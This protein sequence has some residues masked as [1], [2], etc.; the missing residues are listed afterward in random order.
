LYCFEYRLHLRTVRIFDKRGGLCVWTLCVCVLCTGRAPPNRIKFLAFTTQTNTLIM[1]PPNSASFVLTYHHLFGF[2]TTTGTKF[3][4][5]RRYC[6]NCL[7]EI[8]WCR[9]FLPSSIK[10][11][12][13]NSGLSCF[14]HL[15]D[16][17]YSVKTWNQLTFGFCLSY[18]CFCP[19]L[20]WVQFPGSH[21]I[22]MESLEDP[23]KINLRR[24]NPKLYTHFSFPNHY[25]LLDD[26]LH[27]VAKDSFYIQHKKFSSLEGSLFEENSPLFS[28]ENR[29]WWGQME[30]LQNFV[31]HLG[32]YPWSILSI[33]I[34]DSHPNNLSCDCPQK[35]WQTF[36]KSFSFRPLEVLNS[37]RLRIWN[38]C[39]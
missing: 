1:I 8:I 38:A 23:M 34:F 39:K 19:Q 13:R 28:R 7:H 21:N 18:C 10:V 32:S 29:Y 20:W 9:W 4:P 26:M 11:L 15:P 16:F 24:T 2:W 6:I 22:S 14:L 31:L 35:H 12:N 25:Q 17:F 33:P 27:W 36:H 37:V 3:S 30:L 5:R